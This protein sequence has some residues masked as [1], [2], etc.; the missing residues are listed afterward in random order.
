MEGEA[1]QVLGWGLSQPGLPERSIGL[2]GC[3][4]CSAGSHEGHRAEEAEE[5]GCISAQL[6]AGRWPG[7]AELS[8]GGREGQED[9]P[10]GWEY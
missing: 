10:G 5:P 2:L 8:Q 6:P 4:G 9:L 1:E 7:F 3:A